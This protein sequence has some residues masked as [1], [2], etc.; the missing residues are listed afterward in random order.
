MLCKILTFVVVDCFRRKGAMFSWTAD[1]RGESPQ[2]HGDEGQTS[3]ISHS[4]C[5]LEQKV[6]IDWVRRID[7]KTHDVSFD[8]SWDEWV[9]E[10]RVLKYN[11][12]NVQRQKEVS[13]QHATT[14][15]KNKKGKFQSTLN[16]TV[17][18]H[19]SPAN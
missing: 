2:K 17:I 15:A 19:T 8:C 14:A 1:I 5:R 16:G 11:E 12:A 10:N 4:L 6:C 9:P 18:E 7:E 3:E 13:K